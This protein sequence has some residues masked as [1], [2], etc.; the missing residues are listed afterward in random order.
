MP[1]SLK[2]HTNNV[3]VIPLIQKGYTAVNTAVSLFWFDKSFHQH[4]SSKNE[5]NKVK[6]ISLRW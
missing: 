1:V 6:R 5:R 4:V 3:R 2:I